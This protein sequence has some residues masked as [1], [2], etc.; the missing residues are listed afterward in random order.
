MITISGAGAPETPEAPEA[1]SSLITDCCCWATGGEDSPD[2]PS[3]L[4]LSIFFGGRFLCLP[5]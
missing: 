1:P 4:R 2:A 5:D 3:S